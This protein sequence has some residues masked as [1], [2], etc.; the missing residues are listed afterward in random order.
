MGK[1]LEAEVNHCTFFHGTTNLILKD[2]GSR[3]IKFSLPFIIRLSE[4]DR[5]R[6]SQLLPKPSA[7]G[8]ILIT[9]HDYQDVEITG[10]D[11]HAYSLKLFAREMRL[12]DNFKRYYGY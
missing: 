3:D 5:L 7:G 12:L 1:Y 4:G 2:A 10:K 8:C 6:F 9:H 11:G